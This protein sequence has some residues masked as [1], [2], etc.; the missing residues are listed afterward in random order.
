VDLRI[1]V[2]W[3]KG[4]STISN[5]AWRTI[6]ENGSLGVQE[7]K[8]LII[9][10]WSVQIGQVECKGNEV[11]TWERGFEVLGTWDDKL[12]ESSKKKSI[13]IRSYLVKLWVVDEIEKKKYILKKDN[14][15]RHINFLNYWI[16]TTTPIFIFMI[17]NKDKIANREDNLLRST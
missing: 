13:Q 9:A 2:N 15:T 16:K 10:K 5:K 11:I 1:C 4:E 7:S 14:M 6:E 3:S 8:V 12:L 17:T